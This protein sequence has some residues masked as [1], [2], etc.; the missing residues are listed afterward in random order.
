MVPFADHFRRHDLLRRLSQEPG[1]LECC[2]ALLEFGF[3]P[4]RRVLATGQRVDAFGTVEGHIARTLSGS[5]GFGYDPMF[6]PVEA[7]GRS[8]AELSSGEKHAISHRGRAMRAVLA[9]LP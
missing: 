8:M 3:L 7:P 2:T 4:D 6:L 9:A 1:R 5:G